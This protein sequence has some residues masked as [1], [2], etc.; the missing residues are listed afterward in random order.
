VAKTPQAA[1]LGVQ[2]E[3]AMAAWYLAQ[4]YEIVAR[5]WRTKSGEIDIVASRDGTIVIVEVKARSSARFGTGLDAITPTKLA[6]LHRLG[7]AF[8]REHN[9]VGQTM[10]V[11]VASWVNGTWDIVHDV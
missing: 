9:L 11:D 2:A 3:E 1:S 5:N 8:V 10:R 4:G 7:R 6:R